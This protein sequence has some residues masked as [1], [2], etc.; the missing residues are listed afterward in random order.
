MAQIRSIDP[1]KPSRFEYEIRLTAVTPICVGGGEK[2]EYESFEY[3]REGNVLLFAAEEDIADLYRRGCLSREHLA[4]DYVDLIKK[5]KGDHCKRGILRELPLEEGFENK[6]PL[7]AFARSLAVSPQGRSETPVVP[8]SGFKGLLRSGFVAAYLFGKSVDYEY[9]RSKELPRRLSL[10]SL[11]LN[12]GEAKNDEALHNLVYRSCGKN[13]FF[14]PGSDLPGRDGG[15]TPQAFFNLLFGSVAC[16]DM[17]AVAAEMVGIKVARLNRNTG[18]KTTPFFME[19]AMPGSIFRG[20][21]FYLC[22][23][24]ARDSAQLRVNSYLYDGPVKEVST[25]VEL[26]FHGLKLWADRIIKAESTFFSYLPSGGKEGVYEHLHKFYGELKERNKGFTGETEGRFVCKIGYSGVTAKS[27]MAFAENKIASD[28]EFLPYT[29]YVWEARS[30]P[31]GWA[32]VE[33][34]RC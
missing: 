9:A 2:Q 15:A 1:E 6:L 11:R 28:K 21:A 32:Q 8:G 29:L 12:G 16:A 22:D 13:D 20:G 4:A 19:A 3:V 10:Q 7:K 33:W 24:D 17:E 5:I 14:L 34:R 31:V 30:L 26:M 25:P 18:K 23:D 27:M